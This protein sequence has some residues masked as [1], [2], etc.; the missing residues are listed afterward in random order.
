[1]SPKSALV[2]A[3]RRDT[4]DPLAAAAG[5]S[6]RAL[7]PVGGVPMLVRVLRA[8]RGARGIERV[9]VS[10]EEPGALRRDTELARAIDAGWLVVHTSRDSPSKS[11]LAV[12]ESEPDESFLVTTADHALLT[13]EMVDHFV[14]AA[15][16]SDADLAVGFVAASLL[17][18]RYPQST[19]TWLRMRG[20]AWSGANLFA[21]R[22]PRSHAAARF[23]VRA[24][25]HRKRPWR[26][27]AAI[28]P[29]LLV[30]WALGRLDLN[31]ALE[32]ASARLGAR[33]RAVAM[34]EAEAAIDVDRA[35]D[36]ELATSILAAREDGRA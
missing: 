30:A 32:R 16:A 17:Q 23:W 2:L 9:H 12:L 31:A 7:L 35:S 22:T 11:V 25:Q 36:L 3:G 4:S 26:L 28:G 21:F 34:P 27:V 14:A 18:R 5:V 19:R 33:V 10:I 13:P 15:E 6:H 20:E 1:M 24:E 8:L 29:G